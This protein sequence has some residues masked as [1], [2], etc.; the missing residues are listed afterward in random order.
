[1][2]DVNTVSY[3]PT[4]F[5]RA[6]D[7]IKRARDKFNVCSENWPSP[8]EYSFGIPNDNYYAEVW[9]DGMDWQ[10]SYWVIEEYK[11][12]KPQI[13]PL[14]IFEYNEERS[15]FNSWD[16]GDFIQAMLWYRRDNLWVR[17][18]N[19]GHYTDSVWPYLYVEG[20]PDQKRIC[21]YENNYFF[22]HAS[23][24]KVKFWV[25][26]DFIPLRY[27]RRIYEENRNNRD[28]KPGQL[29]SIHEG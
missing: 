17:H 20:N 10:P 25:N 12:M 24:E 27:R 22:K 2:L 29:R 1:M 15:K 6:V 19:L 4:H 26:E 28:E 13:Q 14:I 18:N 11:L 16:F 23:Q 3:Y 9:V 5:L 7:L 21:N 8:T